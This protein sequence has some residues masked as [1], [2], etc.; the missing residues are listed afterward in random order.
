MDCY[1][2][3]SENSDD[4]WWA[5]YHQHWTLYSHHLQHFNE[6]RMRT[7]SIIE[8]ALSH[9]MWQ[10]TYVLRA[11]A[12]LAQEMRTKIRSN[13]NINRLEYFVL[14]AVCHSPVS[15]Y[16]PLQLCILRKGEIDLACKRYSIHSMCRKPDCC[17]DRPLR[18]KTF[19]CFDSRDRWDLPV[20]L[21]KWGMS[22]YGMI[23]LLTINSARPPR[24][25]PQMIAISGLIDTLFWIKATISWTRS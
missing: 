23:V 6:R 18:Q 15:R 24:P 9:T 20:D 12:S 14:T 4:L 19:S 10:S 13:T 3:Y 2:P 7:L 5:W 21:G 1:R 25:E 22:V 16:L 17:D 11:C 8:M